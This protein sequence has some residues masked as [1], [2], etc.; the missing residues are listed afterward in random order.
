[1]KKEK[2]NCACQEVYKEQSVSIETATFQSCFYL[3]K[4]DCPAEEQMVRL[5]L[6]QH[7]DIVGLVFDL[8]Q[9]NITIY[10]QKSDI[11]Q[12]SESLIQLGYGYEYLST[13]DYH[14]PIPTIVEQ[15]K[16][17]YLL[18][19]I[20]VILFCIELIYGIVAQSSGLISDALDMLADAMVYG[21]ALYAVGRNYRVQLRA[22]KFA[23][24][25]Q[26]ILAISVIL[27]TIR[28]FI[29]GSEPESLLMI[30]ISIIALIGNVICLFILLPKRN[31]GVHLKASWIFSAND[32]LINSGVILAGVFV[33]LFE[34]SYPDLIMGL[35][36]GLIVLNG[37]KQILR[38]NKESLN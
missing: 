29:M 36:I 35:I 32:V 21:V 37:A 9:H 38:L 10:H 25:I 1:M 31:D 4:M 34:S 13:Q 11:A 20:N 5:V 14:A 19:I 24:G 16:P 30:L 12:I 22:A 28:R 18:L 26:F 23:G 27:D 2:C 15:K 17:L 3:P 33:M 7:S 6:K 8:P